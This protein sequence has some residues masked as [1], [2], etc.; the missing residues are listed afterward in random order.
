MEKTR[1][2]GYK[3]HKERFHLDKRKKSYSETHKS[4]E[5]HSQRCGGVA[6]TGDAIGQGA[7]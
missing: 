7:R 1:G 6:I 5:P 3:L 4:L 2:K